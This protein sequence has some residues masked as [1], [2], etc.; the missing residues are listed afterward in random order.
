MTEYRG[1]PAYKIVF[2]SPSLEALREPQK[3][4]AEDFDF[5]VQGED[6][7]GFVNGELVN[8]KFNKGTAV[9]KVCEHLHI[10]IADSIAVGDSMNDLEMLK[11]AGISICMAN[12][13]EQLKELVDDVCPSVQ[14]DGIRAA[15]MKYH[16]L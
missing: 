3:I 9:E 5:C 11:T 16:L 1:Q 10:S 14:E 6:Q 13:N 2:M 4:L 15:F 12:G 7:Y 8:R